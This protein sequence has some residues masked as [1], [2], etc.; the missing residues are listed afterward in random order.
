MRARVV[1]DVAGL[2][3]EIDVEM[4]GAPRSGGHLA[5]AVDRGSS[6]RTAARRRCTA[7]N[8]RA[9]QEEHGVLVDAVELLAEGLARAEEVALHLA[10]HLD[11][12]GGL[13]L[14]IGVIAG[15]EIGEESAIL[16]HRVDGIAE[17]AG[18]AAETPDDVPVGRAW[19]LRIRKFLGRP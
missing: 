8:A 15:E 11:D 7:G 2:R 17:K 5:P 14:P 1:G 19:K 9:A 18:L 12:E 4:R 3:Q 16:E 10:I 13:R 6:G